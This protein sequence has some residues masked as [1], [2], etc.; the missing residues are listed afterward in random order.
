[1]LKKYYNSCLL[2]IPHSSYF[3]EDDELEKYRNRD[4]LNLS[5]KLLTD[6]FTNQIFSIGNNRNVISNVFPYNRFYVDPERYFDD[7][8]EPMVEYGQGVAYIKDCFGGVIRDKE[9]I[10]YL[11]IKEIYDNH[12]NSLNNLTEFLLEEYE[13]RIL[14]LDC[15]SFNEDLVD[16][17]KNVDIC[18]GFGNNSPSEEIISIFKSYYESFGYSVAFNLPYSGSL[19]PNKFNNNERLDSIMIEINRRIY[20]HKSSDDAIYPKNNEIKKLNN[21]MR[22]LFI[23]F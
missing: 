19:V 4:N 7:S 23:S 5:I 3:I 22:N 9:N 13:G 18:I 10:N 6:H 1:M 20:L 15:H 17:G 12:H 11:K 21:M 14:F 8:K 16:N 2:H